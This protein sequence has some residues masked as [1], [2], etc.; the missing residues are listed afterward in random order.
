MCTVPRMDIKQG[1]Q[2]AGIRYVKDPTVSL[3]ATAG[4]LNKLQIPALNSCIRVVTIQDCNPS[5]ETDSA[6]LTLCIEHGTLIKLII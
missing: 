2:S 3:Q 5:Q 4:T 1:F 6:V